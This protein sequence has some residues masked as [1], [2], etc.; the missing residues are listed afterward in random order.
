LKVEAIKSNFFLKKKKLTRHLPGQFFL[1]QKKHY[2]ISQKIKR[3]LSKST[4]K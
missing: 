2:R 3:W 1:N 4:D